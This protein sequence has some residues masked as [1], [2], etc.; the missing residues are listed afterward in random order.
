VKE[1]GHTERAGGRPEGRTGLRVLAGWRAFIPR[2]RLRLHVV[3][4]TLRPRT[5]PLAFL[6]ASRGG[7][8][9]TIRLRKKLKLRKVVRF[10]GRHVFALN[11][12]LFPSPAFDHMVSKGGLNI[13]AAGTPLKGQVDIAILAITRK[14]SLA[15]KH[16]YER[17]N[18]ADVDSV[19]VG[20]WKAVV[21]DL[22]R[23]GTNI[24][25][26][27]GGEPMSRFDDLLELLEGGDKDLSDFHLHTSGFDVTREKAR[28]LRAAGLAAAGVGLDDSDAS[29]HD[30]LRGRSGAFEEAVRS[31][32]HFREAGIFPY[33]NICLT[34]DLVRSGR[35]A[36]YLR[37]ARDQGVGAIRWLEPKPCGGYFSKRPEDLFDEDDR[38]MATALFLEANTKR[39]WRGAPPVSYLAY[40][41]SPDRLGCRMGGLMH[42]YVDSLGNVEPCVFLPVSFGNIREENLSAILTRMRTAIPSPVRRGCPG[43]LLF[44]QI[45]GAHE[46]SGTYPVRLEEIGPAW[47]KMLGGDPGFNLS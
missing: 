6:G 4:C 37:F 25:T 30:S 29:R 43:I 44:D 2:L 10:D 3:R 19:S 32:R 9:S 24:I 47:D 7:L 15:C 12:P 21:A 18:L 41:E 26:F 20:Q 17:F 46:R 40:E 11:F 23:L 36:D 28:A 14:C 42:F 8:L 22:Q 5:Y 34:R 27:S 16:C 33:V 1:T 45:T 39:R 31:I 13:A 35:L 38:R